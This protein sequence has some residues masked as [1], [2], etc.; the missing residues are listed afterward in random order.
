MTVHYGDQ[1][2]NFG[3]PKWTTE[4]DVQFG[5][6]K[7]KLGEIIQYSLLILPTYGKYTVLELFYYENTQ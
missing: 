1:N 7:I 5:I 6:P 4:F 2:L 3:I